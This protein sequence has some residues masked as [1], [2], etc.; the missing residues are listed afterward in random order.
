VREAVSLNRPTRGVLGVRIRWFGGAAAAAFVIALGAAPAGAAIFWVNTDNNSIGAANLGKTRA[1]AAKQEFI[2]GL[3]PVAEG[4]ASGPGN[5]LYWSD[6]PNNRISRAHFYYDKHGRLHVQIT[7]NFIT[8]ADQ[9]EGVAVFGGY[10]YWVNHDTAGSIGRALLNGTGAN[11]NFVPNESATGANDIN[12][13]TGIAVTASYIYWDDTNQNSI[14]RAS[15]AT[16]TGVQQ[17]ITGLNTPRGVVVDGGY[18]YWANDVDNG[19]IGRANLD[20]TGGDNSFIT[21]ASGPCMPTIS[22]NYIYWT[23]SGAGTTGSTVGRATLAGTGATERYVTGASSPCGVAVD[24]FVFR[25]PPKP[26]HKHKR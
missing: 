3:G 7:R 12:Y 24:G 14:A 17:F 16:G 2:R 1:S 11:E 10:I 6:S 25:P 23:N 20:G 5:D 21:G 26:K 15:T 19:T 22:G 9:P 18:I 8:G 13:A 4:I